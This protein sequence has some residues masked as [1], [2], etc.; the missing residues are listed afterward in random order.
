MLRARS[1]LA[2]LIAS[3]ISLGACG[4]DSTTEPAPTIETAT[5]AQALGVNIAASTKTTSG[6][7]YRD[8]VV[9]TGALVTTGQTV[10]VHYTGWLTNGTQFDTNGPNDTPFPFVL[11]TGNVIVGWHLG[12]AGMRVGGQ[13]QLIIPPS[14]GYGAQANGK[15]PGN[16]ILVFNVTIVSAK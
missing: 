6:L 11:G 8:I 16:S 1:F 12:I 14:L 3:S 5:F 13:R 2:L 10:S 7:Y 9:G 15:I 4:S